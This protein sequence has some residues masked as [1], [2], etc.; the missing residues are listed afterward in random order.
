VKRL[1]SSALFVLL[2]L[3]LS[4]PTVAHASSQ[5][6]KQQMKQYNDYVKHQN[7]MQKKQTKQQNKQTK[8]WM[9]QHSHQSTTTTVT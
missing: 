4:M 5:S 8:Q 7:K 3:A 6:A 1:T 2:G 9:K